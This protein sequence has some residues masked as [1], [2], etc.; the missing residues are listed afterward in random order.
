M[1]E[2]KEER[3]ITVVE[4]ISIGEE[5][6]IGK[7][8]NTNASWLA[9]EVT[10]LGGRVRRITV[11][12]D[13]VH[14]IALAI[15]EA[16]SRKP[17]LIITTGGLGPTFDDKTMEALAL[18]LNRK[19]EL[20]SSAAEYIRC[21]C[22]ELGVPLNNRRLK[23]A[24]VPEGCIV[25]KNEV[26]MAPG[27]IIERNGVRIVAL[28]GV[29][30]EMEF[31]FTKYVAKMIAGRKFSEA[32]VLVEDVFEA[33]IASIVEEVMKRLPQIYIKTHPGVS[34]R[35]PAIRIHIYGRCKMEVVEEAVKQLI[36]RLLNAGG[37]VKKVS[38]GEK[39]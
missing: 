17:N 5:L 2:A 26:G 10:R 11:I 19:L 18:A 8:V 30:R 25:L 20:N 29:P 38:F 15:N 6:L 24:Y 34:D 31:M 35:G 14:E 13:D 32:E 3:V 22:M 21:K 7:V 9:R 36:S 37:R 4:I 28:P 39:P 23:M 33:D 1:S 12:G 27:V 16:L